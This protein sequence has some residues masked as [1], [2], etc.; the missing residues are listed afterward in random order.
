MAF[1]TDIDS[2]P[3]FSADSTLIVAQHYTLH[4]SILD[5]V[6][7]IQ[8]FLGADPGG[9]SG[10]MRQRLKT[11]EAN[12]ATNT[13]AIANAQVPVGT[14][15]AYGGAT[16]PAGWKLCTGI[17]HGSSALKTVLATVVGAGAASD[18]T[19]DLRDKFILGKGG[20][21]AASGGAQQ[22]TLS[23]AQSGLPAHNHT[24][25]SDANGVDHLHGFGTGWMNQNNVHAHDAWT[26]N[27]GSHGHGA[28]YANNWQGSTQDQNPAGTD[29]GPIGNNPSQLGATSSAGPHAHGVGV[30]SVDINHTH[31]GTTGAMDRSANHTHGVGVNTAG[32]GG[33]TQPVN[34]MNPYYALVYIIKT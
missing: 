15:I 25:W 1:P 24:A 9:E 27:D 3:V 16:A 28:A 31:S 4:T 8:S 18:L 29:Y 17:A 6:F 7:Q 2:I 34:L 13:S 23:A 30:G 12:I 14:I 11:A 32:G 10:T 20:S 21:L 33:A 19:P 22:V 26:G 5:R